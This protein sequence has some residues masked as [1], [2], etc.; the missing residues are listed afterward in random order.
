MYASEDEMNSAKPRWPL[1]MGGKRGERDQGKMKVVL[2]IVRGASSQKS[3][4]VLICH[5]VWLT[6][7]LCFEIVQLP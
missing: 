5:P 7:A 4:A 6:C 2:C 3:F 1:G